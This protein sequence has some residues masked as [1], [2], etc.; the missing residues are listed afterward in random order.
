MVVKFFKLFSTPILTFY[1][2]MYVSNT[3]LGGKNPQIYEATWWIRATI[4]PTTL[5]KMEISQGQ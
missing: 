5:W 4:H 3:I 1:D 2:L